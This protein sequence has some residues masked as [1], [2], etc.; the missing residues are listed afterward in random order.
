[1]DI[2]KKTNNIK[3]IHPA[4]AQS[5]ELFYFKA[6]N[7]RAIGC[8][9]F[10]SLKRKKKINKKERNKWSKYDAQ[11]CVGNRSETDRLGFRNTFFCFKKKENPY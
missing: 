10:L 7:G 3:L 5:F 9:F 8:N 1:M 4:V 2:F 6:S 11:F